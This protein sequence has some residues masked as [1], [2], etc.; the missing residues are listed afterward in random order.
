MKTLKNLLKM[1]AATFL[2]VVV[3]LSIAGVGLVLFTDMSFADFWNKLFKIKLMDGVA[4]ALAGI[5]MFALGM[6]LQVIMHEAGHLLFGLLLGYRF[7]SFRIF[8]FTLIRENGRLCVKRFHLAGTGGQCLL[9]PPERPLEEV[10]VVL[11]NLGGV[12]ANAATALAAAFTLWQIGDRGLLP[13]LFLMMFAIAGLLLALLNG[14]PRRVNGFGNDG[15]NIRLLRQPQSKRAFLSQL[16]VNAL[17]QAGV[18]IKEMPAEWFEAETSPITAMP[19]NST[20]C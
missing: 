9:A 17:C 11:Y 18:R 12:M 1:V 3:G 20:P 19:C 5:V 4:V 13:T 2:G 14:I 6:V 7:V 8:S 10:P 16:G 15:Y